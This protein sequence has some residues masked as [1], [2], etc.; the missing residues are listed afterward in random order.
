VLANLLHETR[1]SSVRMEVRIDQAGGMAEQSYAET[2]AG[3]RFFDV[4]TDSSARVSRKSSYCDGVKCAN[5][6]Y[7]FNAKHKQQSVF[8]ERSFMMESKHGFRDA[9]P[10]YRYYW[11]GQIPLPHA[12]PTGEYA[13]EED[14]LGRRC[15]VFYFKDVGVTAA[16][17]L[18]VYHLDKQ[19]S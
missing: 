13:G 2:S 5:V 18:L 4:T 19:T 15:E 11:V 6:Q 16:K 7:A 12:L 8:L 3:Q 10:P 17:Q 14:V 9:P 1:P